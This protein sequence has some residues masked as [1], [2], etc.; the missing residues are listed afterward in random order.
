MPSLELRKNNLMLDHG[1]KFWDTLFILV[2]ENDKEFIINYINRL[3]CKTCINDSILK[4]D[5]LNLDFVNKSV[6]E[7]RRLLWTLRCNLIKRYKDTDEDFNN[8]LEYLRLI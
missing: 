3:P 6:N 2:K 5:R 8:Y 1:G 7:T 4:I